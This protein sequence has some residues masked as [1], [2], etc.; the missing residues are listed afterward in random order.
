[1]S[2]TDNTKKSRCGK[3]TP[4]SRAW[5]G[6]SNIVTKTSLNGNK[7]RVPLNPPDVKYQPWHK[8]TLVKSFNKNVDLKAQDLLTILRSQLDPTNRGF[9]QYKTGETR[10]TVQF[11][12]YSF[13]VWNLT[14]RVITLTVDDFMEADSAKGGREQLCGLVDT[15]TTVHTPSLGYLLPASHRNHVIRTDDKT[16]SDFIVSCTAGGSDACIL[17]IDCAYRFDGPIT[18]PAL[19]LPDDKLI[20]A[21]VTGNTISYTQAGILEGVRR[22]L[23]ELKKISKNTQKNQ[24]SLVKK[25]IDGVENVAML[26]TELASVEISEQGASSFEDLAAT[27]DP[28]R[29]DGV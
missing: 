18:P 1:M 4:R 20:D 12:F 10:F 6:R 3:S 19:Y 8:V 24:P 22:Q 14:G 26:V 27:E 11:K 23:S 16:G 5:K 9:N 28:L 29:G 21:Q 7:I 25:V 2:G 13:R 17:Y 15:G